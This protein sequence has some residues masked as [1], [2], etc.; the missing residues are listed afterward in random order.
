MKAFNKT[1]LATVVTAA[2]LSAGAA[3]ANPFGHGP[4]IN[5]IDSF[6]TTHQAQARIDN[7]KK[8]DKDY[9]LDYNLDNSARTKIDNDYRLDLRYDYRQDNLN[10]GQNLNQYRAYSSGVGQSGVNLGGASGHSMS[11]S[12][13]DTTVGALVSETNRSRTHGISLLSP[14]YSTS[15]GN[16]EKGNL[17]GSQIGGN[18]S[19]A[20]FGDVTNVQGNTQAQQASSYVG[21]VDW[22]KNG[23]AK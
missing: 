5:Y 9:R 21:S 18:Q 2:A 22:V 16:S 23:V 3:Q 11:Q 4:K 14:S 6:N 13:G 8:I 12:Q 10:A 19:G 1:L 7:S 15:V 17:Y 20:Q